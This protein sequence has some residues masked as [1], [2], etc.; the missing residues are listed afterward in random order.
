MSSL[1]DLKSRWFTDQR[2]LFTLGA[3]VIYITLLAWR[4]DSVP[5]SLNSDAVREIESGYRL[6]K[7]PELKVMTF[8]PHAAGAE[9]FWIS[10]AGL[11]VTLLGHTTLAGVLYSWLAV[12]LMLLLLV[13]IAQRSEKLI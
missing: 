8:N 13:V 7:H 4:V 9:T 2:T 5:P 11:F 10:I 6:I 1:I 3:I 12:V